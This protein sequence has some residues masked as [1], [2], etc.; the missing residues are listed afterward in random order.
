[1]IAGALIIFAFAHA[2]FLRSWGQIAAGVAVGLLVAA[3]WYATG[4]LGA[5]DFNPTPVTSLTFIAPIADAVQYAMLS[6][7]STL[8]FG[9]ATVAGVFAGSLMTALVTRPFPL[10][11]LSVAAPHAALGRRRGADGRGRRDGLWL[12]DRAGPDRTFD[13]GAGVVRRGRRNIVR[14]RARPARRA[15][16]AAAGSRRTCHQI[17]ELFNPPPASRCG[18]PRS[19]CDAPGTCRRFPGCR[20]RC[21]ASSAPSRPIATSIW[22]SMPS[23]VSHSAQS[24]RMDLAVPERH[25]GALERQRFAIGIEPH[26]H[27][28]AGAESRQ[29]EVIGAGSGVLAAGRDRLVGQH[30]MR[31]DGNR[32][33]EFAVAGFAHH[34]LARRF[35]GTGGLLRCD[36]IDIA[37]GPGGDDIGDIGGVA[38][39]DSADDRRPPATQSSWDALPATKMRVALSMPTV[40]SVGECMISSA[41]CRLVTCAIRPCSA[42]SSR[43]SRLMRN[44]R[45][46]SETSTSPCLRMSSMRSLNRPGDM[47][48]I[49]G[50]RDGDD[51]LG[52]RDLRG[53]GQDR[54][55]A[56][57]V[58]DQDRR[59][60][61][62]F[63]QM[64]GGPHQ[65]GDVGG[66]GR[67]G[68]IAFAGAEAREVEP[69]HRDAFCGQRRRDAFRRKHVLAAGEAMREQ[70]IGE[71]LA[72]G[73]VERGRELMAAFAGELETFSRHGSP[74]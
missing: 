58:A 42:M 20:L 7:G 71:R 46:A 35:A 9:I 53:G 11:R 32:L 39:V 72:L 38:P 45:P 21:S 68:E 31:A 66:E 27:R 48:G 65:V 34:D 56:E 67:V 57:A 4:Y 60:F 5:D 25:R 3:G 1:M 61:S 29:Q 18:S 12:L 51:G 44:G 54:G 16:R 37:L 13:A 26:G 33:L 17:R 59:R 30:A 40:S 41:L 62:G 69:Q 36:R 19:G 6:T 49:G 47:G 8:N 70:R 10:G 73:Q 74:P 24:S 22:S 15:A 43:N 50:R 52:V 14:D 64:I 55:A 28:F 63:A 2:P 23:L